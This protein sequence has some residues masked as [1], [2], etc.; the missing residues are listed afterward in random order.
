MEKKL[1]E[2]RKELIKMNSQISMGTTPES[3]GK[4]KLV[5]KTIAKLVMFINEKEKLEV[6]KK[7]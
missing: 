3:P 7:A 5:K 6:A 1:V 4:L 2:L